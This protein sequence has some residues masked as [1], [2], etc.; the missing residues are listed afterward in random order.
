MFLYELALQLGERSTDLAERARALGVDGAGPSTLLTADQVA[1]LRPGGAVPPPPP[2]GAV[3]GTLPPPPGAPGAVGGPALAWAS[4]GSP[5]TP[6]P[7][8]GP[9]APAGRDKVLSP[10]MV[11]LYLVVPLSLVAVLGFVF[12]GRTND[13]RD[14]DPSAKTYDPDSFTS[15]PPGVPVTSPT[16]PARPALPNVTDPVEF[17]SAFKKMTALGAALPTGDTTAGQWKRAAASYRPGWDEGAE[18]IV[19][20]TTGS[21]QESARYYVDSYRQILSTVD[22]AADDRPIS[23]VLSPLRSRFPNLGTSM[24]SLEKIYRGGC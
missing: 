18:S 21:L 20:V 1:A 12:L 16:L 23:S 7:T 3:D 17:C 22:Q 24:V 9:G 6:G 15:L 5:A 14:N 2:G 4:G 11:A 10:A 19:R 13:Q 8:P